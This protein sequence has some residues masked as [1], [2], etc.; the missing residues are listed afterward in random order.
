MYLMMLDGGYDFTA[1]LNGSVPAP[2]S[3]RP[4]DYFRR[5]V[6][7][8]SFSYELPEHL[9]SQLQ[10]TDLLM[11]CSDFPHSEGTATPLPD[12][13]ATGKYGTDPQRAPGLFSDNA[14]F[15]LGRTDSGAAA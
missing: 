10:G 12:Y 5:Q 14:A 2:L 7:V 13:A 8:S 1:R 3:M 11:A 4:S 9:R 15:L 6:R